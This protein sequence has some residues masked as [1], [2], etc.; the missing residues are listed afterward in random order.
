M[1]ALSNFLGRG[2]GPEP[3]GPAE[4]RPARAEEIQP[5]LAM[6]LGSAHA[7][8]GPEQ[9]LEFLQFASGR[10]INVND[11]WVACASGKPVWGIL[12]IT[13]PGHT[14]LLFAP[15]R[16]PADCDVAPLV[17]AVCEHLSRRS[18]YLA[19]ALLD[20]P[21]A[22][23]RGMLATLGFKEMAELVYL[24]VNVSRAIAT[25]ELP[26]SFWWQTY[27]AQTHPLF[28]R[29]ILESYQQSLDCPGLNG[30]RDI[31]DVIAG[32]KAS[33]EFNPRFWFVLSERDMPRGVLLLCRVPRTDASELVYLGLAPVARRRGLADL[34]VRQALWAVREMS[35]SRLTLAVDANNAPALRLY[36]RHGMSRIGSKVA[37]M[38][39]LRSRGAED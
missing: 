31:G 14:A 8:A 33:G 20:P 7:P 16:R 26:E 10:G 23:G 19:Q 12:P 18:T 21:D 34:L 24:Q 9:V 22:A 6:I 15:P 30:L 35:L 5:V 28:E 29:A 13:N 38:R 1:R 27:S 37:L 32:H 17:E 39:D 2:D 25:P 3:F 36:Y 4:Y 11:L